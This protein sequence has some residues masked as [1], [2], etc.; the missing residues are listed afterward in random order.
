GQSEQISRVQQPLQSHFRRLA[1][2][3]PGIV[4]IRY[5]IDFT[6]VWFAVGRFFGRDAG[7]DTE[8]EPKLSQNERNG[9]PTVSSNQRPTSG[10]NSPTSDYGREWKRNRRRRLKEE[11]AK[12]IFWLVFV[13]A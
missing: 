13:F 9:R 12:G 1:F 7:Y 8:K 3:I 5:I 10:T 4:Y 11:I 2:Q 6:G